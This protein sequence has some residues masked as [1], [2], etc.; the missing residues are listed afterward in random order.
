[1]I[2]VIYVRNATKTV[3][4]EPLLEKRKK[5][6]PNMNRLANEFTCVF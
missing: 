5:L 2:E 6:W 3:S 4:T 1:M